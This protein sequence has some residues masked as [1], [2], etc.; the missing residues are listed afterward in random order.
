MRQLLGL[1][2]L[3]AGLIF[4]TIFYVSLLFTFSD[5]FGNSGLRETESP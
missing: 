3:P 1:V 5:S 4:S 2:V